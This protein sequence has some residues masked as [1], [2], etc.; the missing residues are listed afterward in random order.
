MQKEESIML[1]K[2]V[3]KDRNGNIWV[4]THDHIFRYDRLKNKLIPVEQPSAYTIDV[5]SNHFI[6]IKEDKKGNM[7]VFF[8][9]WCVLLRFCC[10]NI[11]AFL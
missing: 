1:V 2:D 4:L 11:Q 7:D 9:Q 5:P 8:T 6:E 3:M 10:K